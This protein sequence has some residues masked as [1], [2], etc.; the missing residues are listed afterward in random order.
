MTTD[1]LE[2]HP[3]WLEHHGASDLPFPD[4][5]QLELTAACDLRCVMCPLPHENRHGTGR[6][7]IEPADLERLRQPLAAAS[8]VELTGFGE[9]LC[10][11]RLLACLRWL[12]ARKLAVHA[13]TNGSRLTREIVD[14]LTAEHL[15]DVLCVSVDA[16]TAP[17]YERIRRGGNFA[18]LLANLDYLAKRR[19]PANPRFWLSFA[20][21]R[22][23]LDELPRFIRLAADLGAERVIV[24]HVFTGPHCAGAG[25]SLT[26]DL[27]IARLEEARQTAATQRIELDLRNPPRQGGD[28][29]RPGLIKDCAFPWRHTFLKANG[30]AAA[31]AMVWED[32]DFA[33]WRDTDF[34]TIWR[35][36]AYRRF[37]LAMAAGDP[38]LPCRRCRYFGWREPLPLKEC[39]P[40]LT[41]D[42][43]ESGL[44]GWGWH[45]AEADAAGRSF[46]WS[47]GRGAF[48]LRP[49]NGVIL[50]IDAITHPQAPH[51][52]GAIK[53][54][55]RTFPFDRHDFWGRPLRLPLGPPD[56]D[57]VRIEWEL[58]DT[59]NPL[60][61]G[62]AGPRR[63]GLLVYGA[64]A[65]VEPSTLRS[66]ANVASS[67]GQLCQGWLD[68]ETSA[69]RP[70]RWIRERADLLLAPAAGR[71]FVD[72]LTPA[73]L[74][75]RRLAVVLDGDALGAQP[76]P[77]DGRWHRLTYPVA[78][79]I[80]GEAAIV[81][82]TVEGA[83]PADGDDLPHPRRFG[84]QVAEIGLAD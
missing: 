73:G 7:T 33:D 68:L 82:L 78:K 37:R 38:P 26:D 49:G 54:G 9:M 55:D 13:T 8:G 22:D 14:A 28:G 43:R 45:P 53:V 11:P 52:T 83:S 80:T 27:V 31:C 29:Y 57:L 58:T 64:R 19:T 51:F 81:V 69:G 34:A 10:H 75:P 12:R 74:S 60:D 35:G 48:F 61:L 41:M 5:V 2:R 18:V 39:G 40:S 20:A 56:S 36:D 47:R 67:S 84:V 76:V 6:E 42:P 32:L 24:Q 46:R 70:A 50:E 21:L 4:T 59:W 23:N 15:L 79:N 3:L 66:I 44:L 1:F 16:A 25:L 71:L 63:L 72:A 62:I 17:T 30:R 65:T 77:G